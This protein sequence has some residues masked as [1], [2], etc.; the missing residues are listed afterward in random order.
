MPTGVELLHH[1]VRAGY[2]ALH[3]THCPSVKRFSLILLVG[4]A[5]ICKVVGSNRTCQVALGKRS[6]GSDPACL[7]EERMR[8]WKL[9]PN[10]ACQVRCQTRRSVTKCDFSVYEV[11]SGRWKALTGAHR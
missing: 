8:I 3:G 6:L 4:G 1:S 5:P 11:D 2:L 7:R 10:A 9:S